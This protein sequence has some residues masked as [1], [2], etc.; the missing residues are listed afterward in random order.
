MTSVADDSLRLCLARFVVSPGDPFNDLLVGC[1]V[2]G[3]D[4]DTRHVGWG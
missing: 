4:R 3:N 2:F 1:S